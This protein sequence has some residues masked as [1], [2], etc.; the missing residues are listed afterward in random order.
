MKR[1]KKEV[2]KHIVKC[3]F[4]IGRK[5]KLLAYP[6]TFLVIVFLA[7]YHTIRKIFVEAQ[8]RKLRTG[9]LGAMCAAVIVGA[10]VVLPT[11]ASET[12]GEPSTEIV[13]EEELEPT[14]VPTT[15]VEPLETEEPATAEPSEEP[16]DEPKEQESEEQK[17]EES[18]EEDKDVIPATATPEMAASEQEN[19]KEIHA[20]DTKQTP[21]PR[22]AAA[23]APPVKLEAPT[24]EV[25]AD[26][27]G[28]HTY[29]LS[30]TVK[31]S[32][33][34]SA[35][36]GA[37]IEYQWYMSSTPDGEGEALN[38]N[39]ALTNTYSVSKDSSAGE[40]YY[41]C[42]IKSVDNDGYNLDSEEVRT[43]N[44][45]VTIGKGEP[46]LTDFDTSEIKDKYYYTG[47]YINPAIVS[48]RE[49]MGKA[50]IVVK[51]GENEN[52][53]KA[54]S[55]EAYPI[56]LH[57]SEGS[58]YKAKTID[59]NKT[60]T[61]SRISTPRTPYTI[62][63]SKG[64]L[65]DGKQWYTSAVSIVPASGYSISTSEDDFQKELLY[66]TDGTNQG[67]VKSVIFLR[68]N[69]NKAITAAI[70]VKE[71]RDGE[72]N[73]DTTA[74]EASITYN[75]DDFVGNATKETVVFNL[76]ASDATSGLGKRYF[77]KSKEPLTDSQ[78]KGVSW[79][80][81][82]EGETITEAEDGSMALYAKVEDVAGNVSYTSTDKLT[83]DYTLP[84]ITCNG[85]P[86]GDEKAYV[87]DRK[88]IEVSDT[89]L[90]RVVITRNGETTEDKSGDDIVKGSVQF[91]LNGP[92][93]MS[94]KVV[95]VITAE[96]TAGNRKVTTVT[97]KNPVLDVD[98]VALDFGSEENALTY[99]YDE[100]EPQAVTLKIKGTEEKVSV[101]AV[102]VE[103]GDGFEVVPGT[104]TV[105]PKQGLHTGTHQAVLRVYY[106]GEE[107]STTTCRC[108]VTV[109]P[110]KMLVRYV[111]QKD[112][113]YHTYPDLE[114]TIEF[115]DT[116]FKNGDTVETLKADEN[117]VMP[118]LYY[119][120]EEGNRQKYT[121]DM[122]A[123]QSMQLIP[124]DG[125]ATD[126]IFE[127]G[128]GELEVQRHSLR[129]GYVI[130]GDKKDGYDWYV[131]STVVIRPAEGYYI[132]R[133]D[134]E[135]SFASAEQLITVNGPIMGAVEKFYVM[136]SETGEISALMSEN[137]KIDNT[138][139]HFRN[140]E[141][142]TV[143]SDLLSAFGNTI[144][145]GIFFNDTKAVAISA[146]DEESGLKSIEYCVS[147]KIVGNDD[148]EGLS[149]Q[150]YEDGF[151]ISPEEYERAV[152]YAKITNHAGLVTYISSN[153]MVFDNKQ[154]DISQIENG[155]EH[156]IV[157]E[158]EYITE[159]LTLKI[160]DCNL[161]HATLF[162]GTNTAV[163]GSA[164]EVTGEEESTKVA[165]RKISCPK[166]GSRTY[167]VVAGDE[168]GNN[169]EREFTITKPVY[170]I[171]AHTLKIKAAEYGYETTPQ[172]AV[173]W[174][175]T[176]NANAN[177]TIKDIILSN[178]RDFEVK[179]TG[180]SFWI[181]AKSDLAHGNYTTDVTLV[182]NGD[183]K[184]ETTC[185]F[186][187]EKATLT[188]T[189]MGDD[190]YYHEK[191][192][193][194]SVKVTGFVKHNGVLE[195]PETA[196]GYQEP[197]VLE[198]DIVTETKEL[199]PSGG[200][201]D[202]YK[203]VYRSGLLLVERRYAS[204]GKDGQ[205]SIDGKISDSGWYTSDVV[206]RPKEGYALLLKENDSEAQDSIELKD[207]TN[208]GEKSFYVTNLATGEIYYPSTLYYKK[209]T[210]L[211]SIRGIEDEATYEANT[212]E[213]TVEDEYLTSVTVNGEAM[214]V[215]Q[216][217]AEFTLTAK[218]E[219]MVYVVVATD[220][221][222]NV[223]DMTI[224]MNQ[225]ETLPV[226]S[227]EPNEVD[228]DVPLPTS[229]PIAGET[230][231]TSKE[232][233][234]KKLVKVVQGAPNT[235]LTTSTSD[236]K[237]SVLSAGEQQAVGNGSNAN[238]ELR[239]KNIDSNVP[240]E[241]K[242]LVIA[243]LGGY[244]VGAYLDITLWKKVGSSI[245]K[246]VTNI[247]KPISI[248]VAVPERL[249]GGSREFV[250]LRIHNGA[251]SV[252]PDRDSAANTV[253]FATDKFS[254]YVLAYKQNGANTSAG[255]TSESSGQA[256]ASLYYDASPEMGDQVP[257]VPVA[258]SFITALAGMI[259]IMLVR[260]R[261]R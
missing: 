66:D 159:E 99:G 131:S 55:D 246:K 186:A 6:I 106:N 167:T 14:M 124:G 12:E 100:V 243:N 218:Q 229:T 43:S 46:S 111:G 104:N 125:Q 172:T 11:L 192:K 217:K 79:K 2:K 3:L 36:A 116:D 13:T 57:V 225:P 33:K 165:T 199:T 255:G 196:A 151:S 62:K 155:K 193:S 212:K 54:E 252:L 150:T 8:Y 207:D 25:T 105:R 98:A 168:A 209:D 92:S 27:T 127:Y 110:A 61:I 242:E 68:N 119:Q 86:L 73:I 23:I 22:K 76:S 261:M 82:I 16:K 219:T 213:V 107:E 115:T 63:G 221:A 135:N 15:T 91:T 126:Y 182:Y 259:S 80:E 38:G 145:F 1:N 194:S 120:D 132:S 137:I 173:T 64:K 47:E 28:V 183:K 18:K 201:A 118:S 74:P 45:V 226:A 81:W 136:N 220:C 202:N 101:D 166:S 113:G 141:G 216:G 39:G 169:A 69:A 31:L 205:Y 5:C 97:L 164:L 240:Q 121:S 206:I 190:L 179:Q 19:T 93:D 17:E 95:Y 7:I 228:S 176:E 234:V 214:P 211:P 21:K 154:P 77:Y 20:E 153:G 245:E 65:V 29:P 163:T 156:G 30:D 96:D 239:I 174:E 195:T 4:G 230:D 148:M 204:T 191:I 40:Y 162:E 109:K 260:K 123:L 152:I 158:K 138:A 147:D 32:I 52:R 48:S 128:G 250:I 187:V 112:V 238:I 203:F 70:T 237:T 208:N 102:E 88:N 103:A 140:G 227:E 71:K 24:Y 184:A 253:T 258:I 10:V 133:T 67:P 60:I 248:T 94:D 171:K 26:G 175:N 89:Y 235:S 143:S 35:P 241:D 222:G 157:D 185:S 49:G 178:T 51:D 83:M 59:L 85:K 149:W 233:T 87:A 232:G 257:V 114:G 181:A 41:Y 117:F 58:N 142:I 251:V 177:A 9:I 72:I 134:D 160:S 161:K 189:Y 254:T 188:A 50:Y 144:T 170:D 53:P 236:L 223:N 249:Q 139:P 210:I 130:V 90:R 224:V 34:A 247:N 197:E 56:Y 146:T 42:K 108:V 215:E 84:V 129:R 75:Q 200:K 244:S 78:L 256:G 231:N 44:I 37:G 198:H 180:G 122:R